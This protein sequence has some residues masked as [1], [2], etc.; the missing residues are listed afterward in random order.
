MTDVNPE[1]PVSEESKPEEVV[2]TPEPVKP[3]EKT[4]SALLLKSLQEERERRRIAEEALAQ[5]NSELVVTEPISDEGKFL[6]SQIDELKEKLSAKE[7]AEELLRLQSSFPAL[8][9]KG[10]EFEA[11]RSNPD[12]AGM[13]LET[14]AKAFLLENDLLTSP[15]SRKGLEK[16]TG[17]ARVV[18]KTE[19]TADEV[20]DLRV[21][22]YRRY[23]RLLAEGKIKL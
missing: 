17:G 1:I 13:K 21:N 8:K 5:K 20:R 16:D 23:V 19:L 12:N 3:G 2:T 18:P 7:K 4:D 14:A 9:D 10:A 15:T 6:K 11:F 22:D